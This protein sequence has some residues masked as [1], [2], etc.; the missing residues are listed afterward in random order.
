MLTCMRVK[1]DY[2]MEAEEGSFSLNLEST[3]FQ[4]KQ[5]GLLKMPTLQD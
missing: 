4:T 1:L 3:R 5:N 2:K